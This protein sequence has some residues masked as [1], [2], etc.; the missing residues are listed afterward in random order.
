MKGG[1]R[2]D[3][4]MRRMKREHLHPGNH[5]HQALISSFLN[6]LQHLVLPLHVHSG[7]ADKY[8]DPMIIHLRNISSLYFL[9]TINKF[10]L[11]ISTCL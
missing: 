6:P 11:D 3:H 4:Q 5:T 9:P 10:H 8:P 7:R 2:M 1:M